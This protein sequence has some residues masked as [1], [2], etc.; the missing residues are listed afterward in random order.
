[1]FEEHQRRQPNIV[2][3]CTFQGVVIALVEQGPIWNQFSLRGRRGWV[4]MRR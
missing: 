3:S 4:V 1:M 2:I